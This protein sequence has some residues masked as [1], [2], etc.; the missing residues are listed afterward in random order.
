MKRNACWYQGK[1]DDKCSKAAL[2]NENILL[3]THVNFSSS[4]T[5]KLLIFNNSLFNSYSHDIISTCYQNK[6]FGDIFIACVCSKSLKASVYFAQPTA[7]L[8]LN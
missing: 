3:P 5:E 1:C 4:D 2:S 6:N 7:H 8:S